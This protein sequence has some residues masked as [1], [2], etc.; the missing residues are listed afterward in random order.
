[1]LLNVVLIP[2]QAYPEVK[3]QGR[4]LVQVVGIVAPFAHMGA[5]SREKFVLSS[6]GGGGGENEPRRR[7]SGANSSGT[8]RESQ[9]NF[10]VG[11]VLDL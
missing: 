7:V 3:L 8:L 9:A 6:P 11:T 2:R 10:K 4:D 1:M 5:G